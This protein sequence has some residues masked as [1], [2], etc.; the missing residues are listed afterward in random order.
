[1]SKH[2]NSHFKFPFFDLVFYGYLIICFLFLA[3]CSSCI[4]NDIKKISIKNTNKNKINFFIFDK[5]CSAENL[6]INGHLYLLNES[7][8]ASFCVLNNC[9]ISNRYDI[10][11]DSFLHNTCL[12]K[13][14]SLYDVSNIRISNASL[15]VNDACLDVNEECLL[16]GNLEDQ[17][18]WYIR[19]V[20]LQ[21]LNLCFYKYYLFFDVSIFNP[22]VDILNFSINRDKKGLVFT[23]DVRVSF[24]ERK[25]ILPI[26]FTSGCTG[27]VL[28]W[29]DVKELEPVKF[30]L[31]MKTPA[32]RGADSM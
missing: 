4:E 28:C 21:R 24:S 16:S 10:M 32:R 15:Y 12:I 8:S 25:K 30:K 1:M 19:Y 3:G 13:D 22:R 23:G 11:F 17:I 31:K 7:D 20:A 9:N 5:Y 29:V 26:P 2:F 6:D 14:I 27:M 18:K